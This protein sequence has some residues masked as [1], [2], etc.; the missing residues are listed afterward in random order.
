MLKKQPGFYLLLIVK[1]ERKE[2]NGRKND[3]ANRNQDLVI[4]GN[5]QPVQIAKGAKIKIFNARKVCSTEKANRVTRQP[6]AS[7]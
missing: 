5:F 1:Y 4:G 6:F 7:N 3:Y 2:I